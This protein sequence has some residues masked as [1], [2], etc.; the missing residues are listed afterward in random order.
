MSFI[1]QED[2]L[3]LIEGLLKFSW[4]DHLPALTLSFPH[5][6][7]DEAIRFY[8]SDKPDTRFESMVIIMLAVLSIFIYL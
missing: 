4:P 1:T 6:N 8:G 7:Y 5:M 3:N 2:I